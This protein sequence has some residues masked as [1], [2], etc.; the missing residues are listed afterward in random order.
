MSFLILS[1]LGLC[2]CSPGPQR[3]PSPDSPAA[4]RPNFIILDI[5]SMRVDRMWATRDGKPLA[6]NLF[7]LGQQGLLFTR[8]VAPAGWTLP[9]LSGLLTGRH[10]PVTDF[11]GDMASWFEPGVRTFPE[12]LQYYGYQTRA[13][14][15]NT[16]PSTVSDFSRRFGETPPCQNIDSCDPGDY[17]SDVEAWLRDEAKEPFLLFIHNFD[18][19][20]VEP[21][22]P[23][24]A[25][26]YGV[27]PLPSCHAGDLDRLWEHITPDLSPSQARR[28][29][30]S[31]Y[32]GALAWYD[33]V[34][35]AILARIKSMGI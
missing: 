4:E 27:Q 21:Q 3:L 25:L 1:I 8:A 22:L 31:H 33:Q 5:D 16:F 18:L 14:W 30:I 34:V 26:H 12:I 13:F 20:H 15:G 17:H 2:S 35:G 24:D 29:V 28:H 32:D 7:Q 11:V 23:D 10:P 6:P 19:H 9:A